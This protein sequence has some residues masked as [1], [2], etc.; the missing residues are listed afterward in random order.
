M[1]PPARKL[2][3][4]S[5]AKSTCPLT[6]GAFVTQGPVKLRWVALLWVQELYF[7]RKKFAAKAPWVVT[8]AMPPTSIEL[9]RESAEVTKTVLRVPLAWPENDTNP[10]TAPVLAEKRQLKL[11]FSPAGTFREVGEHAE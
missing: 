6:R 1:D 4:G 7:N 8:L 9:D 3:L 11:L 10:P 2:P 5:L